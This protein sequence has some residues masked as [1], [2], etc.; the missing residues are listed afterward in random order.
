MAIGLGLALTWHA[1]YAPAQDAMGAEVLFDQGV[2]LMK[3]GK[4]DEGC[5][6]IA[7]SQRL[8]PRPGTL[9]T[10]A[11]CLAKQGKIATALA[12]Y[13][14][15]LRVFSRMSPDQRVQQRGRNEIA[16]AK[17][18]ELESKV[19]SLKI[20]LPAGAPPGSKVVKDGVELGQASLDT[21]LPVDPGDHVFLVQI[22]DGGRRE[23]RAKI[24]IGQ[25]LEL[26]LLVPAAEGAAPSP[27]DP[28][29]PA[30]VTDPGGARGETKSNTLAWIAMGVG[31]A[32][33]LTS[34]VTGA[35]VLSKKSTIDENCGVDG[36]PAACNSEGKSAADSAQTLALVSTI[37]F[38]VGVVG[39]GT[40]TALMLTGGDSHA[41]VSIT[42]RW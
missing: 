21:W 28:P 18:A 20:V 26:T 9:F 27:G 6:K 39:I 33:L 40:G 10:L 25:K 30:P 8:E 34:A 31:A 41:S 17:R 19:P 32:G 23:T 16:E 22:P 7:E 13:E 35:L 29:R 14:E 2:Q 12:R 15:Y 11:E 37:G 3:D 1:T 42:G 4:Y 24:A 38:A 5:P 36:D